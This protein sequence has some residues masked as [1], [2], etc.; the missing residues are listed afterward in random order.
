MYAWG[1]AT[2]GQLALDDGSEED[3]WE[4]HMIKGKQLQT[5]SVMRASAGGQHTVLLAVEDEKEDK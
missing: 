1:M 4:P 2:N 5:R 3:V